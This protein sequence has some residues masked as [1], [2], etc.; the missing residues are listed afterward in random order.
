MVCENDCQ[1]FTG[2]L[3]DAKFC[4]KCN[5]PRSVDNKSNVYRYLPLI[6]QLKALFATADS[7]QRMRW[8]GEHKASAD[9]SVRDVTESLGFQTF[10]KDAGSFDDP[11]TV[12]LILSAD[13][14]A[15]FK[16][17]TK[18]C[19]PFMVQVAN[20]TP[21]ERGATPNV[22]MVGIARRS[23][24]NC[25]PYVQPLMD[26]VLTL[27]TTGVRTYDALTKK[28]FVMRAKLLLVVADYP[29]SCKLLCMMG[30][31]TPHGCLKCT[32]I[33]SLR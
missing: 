26:E 18:S 11:R 1:L 21:L 17:G 20:Q 31:G 13:G 12:Q 30:S 4:R 7:S 16:K 19:C 27:A 5:A 10:V 14:I 25:N 9:G 22:L 24:K 15:T 32:Y 29:G 2:S 33:G 28:A 23:P 8:A 3:A 6:P